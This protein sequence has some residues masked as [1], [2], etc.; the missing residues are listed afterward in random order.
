MSPDLVI[1]LEYKF[2][3]NFDVSR[4]AIFEVDAI[5][6]MNYPLRGS[7]QRIGKLNERCRCD[8]FLLVINR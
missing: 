5:L 6:S 1:A 7:P 4:T 3:R 2:R 8:S